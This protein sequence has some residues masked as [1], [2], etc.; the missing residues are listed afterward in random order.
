MQMV[1]MVSDKLFFSWPSPLSTSLNNKFKVKNHWLS[2][3]ILNQLN[4]QLDIVTLKSFTYYEIFCDMFFFYGQIFIRQI[5]LYCP[6]FLYLLKM[7]L[8]SLLLL[9]LNETYCIEFFC[10]VFK[11]HN[12]RVWSF[13]QS[14]KISFLMMLGSEQERLH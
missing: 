14:F 7:L 8:L 9:K 6:N 3:I 10:Q 4:R 13:S 2:L 12:R 1:S 11:H 5:F